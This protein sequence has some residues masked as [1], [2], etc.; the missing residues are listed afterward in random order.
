MSK[1]KAW[2]IKIACRFLGALIPGLVIIIISAILT[3][4]N[5]SVNFNGYTTGLLLGWISFGM[6]DT[7]ADIAEEELIIKMK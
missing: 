7:S 6:V 2:I 4:F 3:Y 1:L 5:K